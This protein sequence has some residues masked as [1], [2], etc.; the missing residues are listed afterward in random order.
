MMFS[1]QTNKQT[2]KLAKIALLGLIGLSSQA[3]AALINFDLTSSSGGDAYNTG[4]GVFGDA[5]SKWNEFSRSSSASN[6]ALFDDTG[7]TTSV[8][9]S[10]TKLISG[11][12]NP[13]G[14]FGALG[15]SS[16]FTS[17][18]NFS[19]LTANGNYDLVVFSGWDE[20][21]SFSLGNDTKVLHSIV[22]WSSLSEGVQYVLF[23]GTANSSGELSFISN[24]NPGAAGNA[25]FWSAFQLRN[26]PSAVPV[27]A[28]VWLFGSG[29][30]GLVASR[31]KK[32]NLAA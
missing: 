21:P 16:I 10:Y 26:T 23:H 11:Y 30:V 6:L 12:S 13:T 14:T 28:A 17:S 5:L 20:I 7:T 24:P 9:V 18:V 4:V 31:R 3:H 27:P 1:K 8:K 2:N 15:V 22:N 29:L 25:S 19:G 32:A